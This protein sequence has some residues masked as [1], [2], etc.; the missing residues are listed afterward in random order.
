VS[1]SGAPRKDSDRAS[2]SSGDVDALVAALADIERAGKPVAEVAASWRFSGIEDPSEV[3]EWLD[4]GV[5]DGHRAGLLKLSG[6]EARHLAAVPDAR[7]LGLA[8]S[9]GELSVTEVSNLVV[10]FENA[11]AL[12]NDGETTLVRSRRTLP[13]PRD[14]DDEPR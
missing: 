11:Q 13:D 2:A 9:I 8:F 10:I 3:R 14:R 7:K 12:T 5:F 6:V 1:G 4:V